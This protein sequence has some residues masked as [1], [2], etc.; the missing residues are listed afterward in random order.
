MEATNNNK[1]SINSRVKEIFDDQKKKLGIMFVVPQAAA[2]V[3]AGVLLVI[4]KAQ[5][6]GMTLTAWLT[7]GGSFLAL[8]LHSYCHA[9]LPQK[10]AYDPPP[11]DPRVRTIIRFIEVFSFSYVAYPAACLI[12]DRLVGLKPMVT[13]PY[14]WLGLLLLLPALSI[15]VWTL[16]MF[17][18]KGKGTAIPFEATQH[19]VT[20]GPYRY[21]RNP[22]V[23]AGALFLG[24]I[25]IILGSYLI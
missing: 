21:V 11:G 15:L 7:I 24:G 12:I 20:E 25:S 19:L 9:T 16:R 3:F 23:T 14:N 6:I 4:G 18:L 2:V 17:A 22:M 5:A 1:S 10:D 8:V 13:Y